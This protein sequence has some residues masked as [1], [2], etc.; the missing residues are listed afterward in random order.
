MPSHNLPVPPQHQP[1]RPPPSNFDSSARRESIGRVMNFVVFAV[2]PPRL[3][4]GMV[5]PPTG[6]GPAD[7]MG[8]DERLNWTHNEK[9]D[10]EADGQPSQ[11]R[12]SSIWRKLAPTT[13]R[14]R[15]GTDS[16]NGGSELP[17]FQFKQVPYDV[18]RKHY[19]KDAQ[20]MYR[21]THAPAE[22]CLLKPEDV[23]KWRLEAPKT[24]ADLWTRGSE[25]LPVYGEVRAEE[26][27]P[28]YDGLD[29]PAYDADAATAL[30]QASG[31]P[32]VDAPL[33]DAQRNGS[34]ASALSA[35]FSHGGSGSGVPIPEHHAE[36]DGGYGEESMM[37]PPAREYSAVQQQ[38]GQPHHLAAPEQQRQSQSITQLPQQQEQKKIIANGMTAEQIIAAEKEKNANKPKGNMSWKQ[39]VKKGTE[40]AMMGAS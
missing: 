39:R 4:D 3:P 26:G 40:W 15:R 8:W 33:E 28:E 30:R 38:L 24:K 29:A 13:Q 22:D 34:T 10:S 5:A 37:R 6:L 18:W 31:E 20:G 16:N 11:R 25:A 23:A 1:V 21:G 35:T 19:A 27:V 9:V 17:P 32:T 12:K 2:L 14:T 7:A 36:H